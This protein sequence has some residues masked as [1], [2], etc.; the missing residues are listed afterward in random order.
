MGPMLYNRPAVQA[1]ADTRGL[2]IR[3]VALRWV[4]ELYTERFTQAGRWFLWP[5][6][7]FLSFTSTSPQLPVYVAS[8][9]A[10]GIWVVAFV[11]LW[12]FRPRVAVRARHADRACAGEVVPVDVEVEQE[13][14][15][16][17]IDLR[18]GLHRPPAGVSVEPAEGAPLPYLARGEK[19]HARFGIRC[20]RRGVHRLAGLAV[21]TVFPLGLLCSSRRAGGERTL[22]IYPR[23]QRLVRLE[24]PAGRRHQPGGVALASVVGDAA[25][26]IGDR[27]WRDGD[28]VRDIDWRA[29]ARL[30]RIVVREFREEYFVRVALILDTHVPP[31]KGFFRPAAGVARRRDDFERAVSLCAAVGDWLA[32]QEYLVELFAAGAS[33]YHLTAGRSLAYL[34]QILDILACVEESPEAAFERIEPE[35]SENLAQISAV[36]L[37]FL[38]WDEG[39]RQFVH[40]LR[41]HGVAVKVIIAC[42]GRP[43]LDPGDDAEVLGEVPVVS[44]E[45]FA[46]GVDEL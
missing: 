34:D 28:N 2:V 9:Y 41:R 32:R 21:E 15:L 35:L 24:L 46:A 17:G 44:R 29:T 33:L 6:I 38:D 1:R 3:S 20:E 10:A 27:E 16:G 13:G 37:L 5:T 40:K 43:T 26:F 42:D 19:A 4:F 39:R 23:F 8:C 36:V 11:G 14:R 31:G 18:V 22:L 7:A 25:E 12:L 45:R 30:D